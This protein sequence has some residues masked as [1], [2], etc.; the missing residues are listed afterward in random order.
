M[1]YIGKKRENVLPREEKRKCLA[2]G[3]KVKISYLRQKRENVL[4]SYG[5]KEHNVLPTG[6]KRQCLT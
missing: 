3:R 5:R 1:S 6:E 4:P 2:Q